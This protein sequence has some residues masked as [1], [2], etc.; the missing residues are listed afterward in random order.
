MAPGSVM[1]EVTPTIGLF[2]MARHHV[3]PAGSV[4][5]G[6]GVDPTIDPRQEASSRDPP[7][8]ARAS[9]N[10]GRAVEPW[11]GSVALSAQPATQPLRRTARTENKRGRAPQ[12]APTP[13]VVLWA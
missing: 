7:R 6:T 2:L 5:Y 3:T 9:E 10:C 1:P 4:E 11:A 8:E 13:F 12:D